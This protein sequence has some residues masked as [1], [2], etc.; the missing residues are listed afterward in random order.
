MYYWILLP[1]QKLCLIKDNGHAFLDFPAYGAIGGSTGCWSQKQTGR[2]RD[3]QL[4]ATT[5]P[6]TTF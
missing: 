4:E 1:V 6:L 5:A 2:N 3:V